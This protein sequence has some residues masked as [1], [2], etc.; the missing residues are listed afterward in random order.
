MRN[1][2][3]Y[4]IEELHQLMRDQIERE[5]HQEWLD[6][7]YLKEVTPLSGRNYRY[8]VAEYGGENIYDVNVY[9][10]IDITGTREL[11]IRGDGRILDQELLDM[12]VSE[13]K[14]ILDVIAEKDYGRGNFAEAKTERSLSRN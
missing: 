6:S 14:N 9:N 12:K 10:T 2:D 13:L 7:Y 1:L 8:T 11:T 4:P 3:D 5:Q